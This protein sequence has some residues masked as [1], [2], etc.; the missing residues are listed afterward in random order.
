MKHDLIL[1]KF[2]LS[3]MKIMC[4]VQ[5]SMEMPYLGGWINCQRIN[6]NNKKELEH[7]AVCW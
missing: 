5:E 3:L 1:F 2:I 7:V 4:L 6:N